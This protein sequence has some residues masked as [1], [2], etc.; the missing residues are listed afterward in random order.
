MKTKKTM[1]FLLAALLTIAFA[2]PAYA[3]EQSLLSRL[4]AG[5]GEQPVQPGGTQPEVKDDENQSKILD[6]SPSG[7]DTPVDCPNNL[8]DIQAY[9]N[10]NLQDIFAS[11]HLEDQNGQKIVLSFSE[12]IEKSQKD[13]L[14]ALAE[15]PSAL[16]FRTV[17]YCENDLNQ[18][19]AE[20]NQLWSSLES[21]GI[22]IY[23][24]AIN[25][26]INRVEIGIDPFNEDTVLKVEQAFGSDMIKVVQG[27]QA[28]LLSN[29][30]ELMITEDDAAAVDAAAVSGKSGFLQRLV[31]FFKSLFKGIFQ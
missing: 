15:D 17:D 11:L 26:F 1:V 16:V 10:E 18:K 23:H 22:K 8:L 24:T 25:V 9:I 6:R 29:N 4:P 31:N 19:M 21:E 5:Y 3:L 13:E 28:Q 2:V 7:P 14:L 30:A 27:H 12:E 20:I